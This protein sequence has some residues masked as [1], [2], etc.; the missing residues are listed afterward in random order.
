MKYTLTLLFCG[1]LFISAENIQAQSDDQALDKFIQQVIKSLNDRDTSTLFSISI[2]SVM[3][4]F[5]SFGS[6]RLSNKKTGSS[7]SIRVMLNEAVPDHDLLIMKKVIEPMLKNNISLDSIGFG[8]EPNGK[9]DEDYSSYL[10]RV[11]TNHKRFR[12]LMFFVMHFEGAYYWSTHYKSFLSGEEG[13]H[14]A[15]SE[16]FKI[17]ENE[18]GELYVSGEMLV[19]ED[20]GDPKRIFRYMSGSRAFR[21]IAELDS[22]AG[23]ESI[24]GKR[25]LIVYL[26][27]QGDQ[28]FGFVNYRF[29]YTFDQ[30]II[31]YRFFDVTHNPGESGFSSLGI[32]KPEPDDEVLKIISQEQHA[33]LINSIKEVLQ[34]YTLRLRGNIGSYLNR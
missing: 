22:T 19:S 2:Q 11:K 32:L 18:K 31:H 12:H 23:K 34:T 9:R 21:N 28:D 4:R 3:P 15:L 1:L 8:I 33:F 27:D 24:S 14:Q 16:S 13:H 25:K 5:I 7:D 17:S 30:G 10:V 29:E 6:Q 20:N 26:D